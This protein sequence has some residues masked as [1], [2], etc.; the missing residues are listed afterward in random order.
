M[1]IDGFLYLSGYQPIQESFVWTD[2]H[3]VMPDSIYHITDKGEFEVDD[4]LD[5]QYI[6]FAARYKHNFEDYEIEKLIEISG[7]EV[8]ELAGDT[9][10][11]FRDVYVAYLKK[12][13]EGK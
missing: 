9:L 2:S 11:T 6:Y 10:D 13:K 7:R 8:I 5:M 3:Q 12:E 1:I 4:W